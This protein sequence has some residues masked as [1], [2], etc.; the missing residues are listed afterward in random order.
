MKKTLRLTCAIALIS[1]MCLSAC[2]KAELIEDNPV[3]QPGIEEPQSSGWKVAISATMGGT[4]TKALAEDP[5]TR[6]LIATFETTDNIF[7][8]NK[9]KKTM[10]SSPLHPDRDG[11]SVTL[12]GTLAGSYEEGDELV[13]CYNSGSTGYS[14]TKNRKGRSRQWL[15]MQKPK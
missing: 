5:D 15:T 12:T 2:N 13:L 1:A 7:V 4:G 9:T 14:T 3:E 11:A 8:Y 6:N 10:D